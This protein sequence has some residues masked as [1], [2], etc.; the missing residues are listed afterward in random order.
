[1]L[2]RYGGFS[3][4]GKVTQTEVDV[5]HVEDAVS[6]FRRRYQVTQVKPAQKLVLLK[7]NSNKKIN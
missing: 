3:L 2:Y 7:P 4:G 6:A 5:E 1:M